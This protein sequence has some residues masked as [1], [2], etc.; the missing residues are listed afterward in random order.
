M[1]IYSTISADLVNKIKEKA[2]FEEEI[3]ALLNKKSKSIG[4]LIGEGNY[5]EVKEI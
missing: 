1:L 3:I 4:L 2:R 5:S